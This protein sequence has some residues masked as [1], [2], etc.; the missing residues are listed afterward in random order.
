MKRKA[1]LTTIATLVLALL[2][3]PVLTGCSGKTHPEETAAPVSP[4]ETVSPTEPAVSPANEAEPG[5]QDGERFEAVILLEGLEE[6][7]HYEHIK[8]EALG[9][10]MDYD[11][12]SFVRYSGSDR[13]RFIS[14]WDDPADPENYLE[15]SFRAEGVEPVAAS[16]RE[17][18]SQEYELY[19]E[20]RELDH[21]GKCVY[22]EASVLKGTNNMADQLQMVYIIPTADGCLVAAE[23]CV[24]EAAEG[25]GRCFSYMVNTLA[26]IDRNGD[27]T[28]S[29]E[30]AISAIRNYCIHINP[31]LE[32]I[33]NAG[34]Y[35]VCWELAS[36]D[37]QQ[38]VVLFRSYTGAQ[39]RY[40]ID[41]TSGET[42]VTEFVPGVTPEE[43]RT[44]ESF[45][46][47]A[48]F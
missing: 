26:V 6:T 7:V 41:R 10:E 33:V 16:I 35:S 19:E 12:E 29:D 23:H 30:Q 18:L 17:A 34:E 14:T 28:L 1:I 3:T 45:N 13:E 4:T 22:I 25:F 39:L 37:E 21:T 27:G 40:Y 43:E 2:L 5:R 32:E 36:S 15:V 8:N 44:D 9:L 46:V 42:Y 11:Y 47:R 38:I 31:N 24:V 48:F 20:S